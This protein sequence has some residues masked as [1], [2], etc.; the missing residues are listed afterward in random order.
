MSPRSQEASGPSVWV[1]LLSP[2]FASYVTKLES[3]VPGRISGLGLRLH[4]EG[5]LGPV[6]LSGLTSWVWATLSVCHS[7]Q[8]FNE[9]LACLFFCLS[10]NLSVL[11]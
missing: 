5:Q 1:A 9:G 11:P 6:L 4:A 10:V 3:P 2:G 8:P 7:N